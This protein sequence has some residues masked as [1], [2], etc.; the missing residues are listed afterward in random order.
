M[1]TAMSPPPLFDARRCLR[2]R[3]GPRVLV[4]LAAACFAGSTWAFGAVLPG[5]SQLAYP[6]SVLGASGVPHAA[7]FNVLGFVLPGLLMGVVAAGECRSIAAWGPLARIGG[8]I[9]L[10][11]T[12]AFMALGLFPLRL[13]DS[14]ATSG[15]VHIACWSLWW[16]TTA[17]GGVLLSLGS[18]R[19]GQGAAWRI[20]GAVLAVLV[21]WCCLFAPA[22]WG[23]ALSE[24]IAFGLWFGWWLLASV[25][26]VREAA[27]P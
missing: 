19:S 27:Q 10:F 3:R 9:L 13:D 25:R 18:R 22:A 16:L 26:P 24:R 5:Y 21:P 4:L 1:K 14:G 6:V 15:R 17:T 20:G 12:L 2:D 7:G 8:W 11:S 23:F